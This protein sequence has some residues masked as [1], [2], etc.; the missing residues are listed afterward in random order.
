MINNYKFL[1]ILGILLQPLFTYSSNILKSNLVSRDTLYAWADGGLNIRA[2]GSVSADVIG[3]IPYGGRMI[4]LQYADNGSVEQIQFYQANVNDTLVNDIELKCIDYFQKGWWIQVKYE[5]AIGYV[6]SGYTSRYKPILAD[7]WIPNW[8]KQNERL[9][10]ENEFYDKNTDCTDVFQYF[11]NGIS[12][13]GK[14]SK[15][16]S[17]TYII[18]NMSLEEAILLTRKQ[19]ELNM[20]DVLPKEKGCLNEKIGD[21]ESGIVTYKVSNNMG[22]AMT[23]TWT[24]NTVII[25][26]TVWC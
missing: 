4:F 9:I 23:I 21:Q 3:S 15:S 11:E 1:V 18:P 19:I 25:R 8:I 2:A 14:L 6:F 13:I 22:W 16:G 20:K 7:Y 26:E 17:W 5:N 10:S 12:V 24:F